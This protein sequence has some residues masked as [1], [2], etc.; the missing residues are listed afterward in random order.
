VSGKAGKH[1]SI[2]ESQPDAGGARRLHSQ[3]GS[4][5]RIKIKGD[6]RP[7]RRGKKITALQS[8]I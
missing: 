8:E 3:W 2:K 1:L 5:T 7:P 4:K 6:R